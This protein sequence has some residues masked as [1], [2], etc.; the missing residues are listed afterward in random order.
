MRV[1]EG[2]S[3]ELFDVAGTV[4]YHGRGQSASWRVTILLETVPAWTTT[5]PRLS[6]PTGPTSLEPST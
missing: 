5:E 4:A 3:L 1:G 2:A 6:C